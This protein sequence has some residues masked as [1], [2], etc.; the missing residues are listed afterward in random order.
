MKLLLKTTAILLLLFI[1]MIKQIRAQTEYIS[2]MGNQQVDTG[3]AFMQG[4]VHGDPNMNIPLAQKLEPAFWELG[5][6]LAF[7]YD[8]IKSNFNSKI[9]INISGTY[10]EKM[11]ISNPQQA[12]PW[13][14]NWAQWDAVVDSLIKISVNYNRPVD[15]WCLFGEPDNDFK[16]TN[17]QFIE[18]HRR[19]DSIL[20]ANDPDAKLEGPDF[21]SFGIGKLLWFIDS[22]NDVNVH[23]AGI[24]WHEFGN[25]PEDVYLH[26]KQLRDSLAVRPQVGNPE[27]FI[28]EFA[29]PSNRLIPGWNVRMDLLF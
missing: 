22:L 21:V 12:K 7:Y 17:A 10:M 3:T 14:N 20:K 18:M 26:V 2:V 6:N 28:P 23:L 29:D 8:F 13:L 1:C 15:Y 19:T 11:L 25:Y 24:S 16:G 9:T 27:I 5:W 4:F